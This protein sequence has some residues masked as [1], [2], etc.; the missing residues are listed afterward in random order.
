MERI[1][2]DPEGDVLPCCLLP[3][4]LKRPLGNIRED[5]LA[6]ICSPQR[7]RLD[8]TAHWLLKGHKALR[9]ELAYEERSHCLCCTCTEMLRQVGHRNWPKPTT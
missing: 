7:L 3:E 1:V 5:G 9:E 2:V 4:D 8:P 6:E